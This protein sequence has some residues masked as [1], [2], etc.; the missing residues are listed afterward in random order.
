MLQT[1]VKYTI[2]FLEYKYDKYN[3][4]QLLLLQGKID[5]PGCQAHLLLR[6]TQPN[7]HAKAKAKFPRSF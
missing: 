5:L 4:A 6:E 7:P 2:E 3:S 1:Q